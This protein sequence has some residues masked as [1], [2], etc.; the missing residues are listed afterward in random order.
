MEKLNFEDKK[1]EKKQRV[2]FCTFSN[3]KAGNQGDSVNDRKLFNAIPFKY[4]KVAIY[5]KYKEVN[6][7]EIKSIFKCIK[8][9]LNEI[10]ASKRIFMTRAPKLAL[11]P[12]LLNKIFN[13]KVII[14]MGLHSCCIY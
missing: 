5:P 10:T 11:L 13:N 3:F 14:R 4:E 12:I 1:K 9:F 7:I 8:K 6:K 2:V